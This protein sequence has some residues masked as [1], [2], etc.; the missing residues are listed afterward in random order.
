MKSSQLVLAASAG[1]LI[2][3]VSPSVATDE[4]QPSIKD[5]QKER[6]QVLTERV[7]LVR[8]L[9]A[10]A[11]AVKDE[12]AFWEERLAV[13]TAELEGR[14]ADLR[15]IYERRIAALREAEKVA[16]KLYKVQSGSFAEVL[17]VREARLEVEIALARLK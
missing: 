6:V 5:L 13:A 1:V 10:K 9:A 11:A 14:T 3:L 17:E 2:C 16:E 4:V 12:V 7:M 15:R 8:K